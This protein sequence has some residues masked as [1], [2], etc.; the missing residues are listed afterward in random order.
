MLNVC[1]GIISQMPEVLIVLSC[2]VRARHL[3]SSKLWGLCVMRLAAS[4]ACAFAICCHRRRAVEQSEMDCM[5]AF[6][7]EVLCETGFAQHGG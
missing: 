2:G 4:A 5:I 1:G 6:Y 7:A 3:H